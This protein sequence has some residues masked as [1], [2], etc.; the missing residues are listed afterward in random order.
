MADPPIYLDGF[1]YQLADVDP[2]ETAEWIEALD[3]V[4][5]IDGTRRAGYLMSRLLERARQ[6]SVAVP[7]S[8]STPYVN[9]IP[10]ESDADFPGDEHLEKRIRRF[11][12]WNAAAMV[13]RANH[14]A[15][16]IGGHLSTFASSA[17]LYEVGFNHFFRGK[18]DG[19]PGDHIY[20]QG[21]AT[22]GLYA[23]AFLEGRLDESIL[24]R[25]RREIGEP[26][27]SSYPHP[28]LMPDFW[29]YPTVSMG[30]GP[31]N[32][33][34]HAQFLKYLHN[35]GIDDTS[36]TRIWSF[37]GDGETDEPETLGSISLA[38]RENLDNL[39]WV[40]NCNLQRL[41]GPV[42]GNGK[43]IQELEAMFRG[44]G[45]NVIKVIWGS[46]WDDLL[47]RDT[48]GALVAKM[49]STVDGEYQRFKAESGAYVRENFFG[50]EAELQA[51]V[52]DMTDEEI[53]KLR[54]G[55]LDHRKIYSAYKSAVEVEGAP[56]AI[57][58]KT[59]KGWT[60][61]ADV[62]GKN[63]THSIKHLTGTQLCDLRD[64]L[65][66]HDEI[67][68][69]DLEDGEPPYLRF[70]EDSPEFQYLMRRRAILN[71]PVPTR[72]LETRSP[73]VLPDHAPF[74]E[75]DAGSGSI[76]VSTTGAFTRLLRALTR[77]ANVG[78]RIVPIIPDEGRTF[79]MDALFKEIKIYASE[80]QLYEP[81][82]HDLILS[83]KESMD[84]QILEQGITEAG[85]T[86]SWIAAATS[87]VTRGVPMIPFYTFYSMFGFQRVG[88][89]L[90]AASD[91]GARGFLLG[92][93]AGRTTLLGEGLQHQDGHSHVLASVI[94]AC[95]TY[96]PAFAYEM[97][98]IIEHGMNRMYARGD[99]VFYYLTLYNENYVQPPKPPG[100]DAGIIAGMYRFT[101]RARPGALSA[102]ILF[103][104]PAH[105]AASRAR[106]ELLERY[107]VSADTWSVT[108]YKKLREDALEVE[109]WNRF[110]PQDDSRI[111]SITRNLSDSAGPVVAV[112][113]Y[114]RIVPDQVARFV[115]RPYVSLGTDGY[116]RSDTREALR[117]FFEVRSGDIV[118]AVLSQLAEAG[119]IDRSVVVEAIDLY[120]IDPTTA[121]PWQR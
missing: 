28:R 83:Y 38:G 53:W 48:T 88:D 32:S 77:D 3:S 15:N 21:H 68:D 40:V 19:T 2:E 34:Y 22:P 115:R 71:G 79:G 17:T 116:G 13:I 87:Y 89:A 55:G 43:I 108:S 6:E 20:F 104:G 70:S 9:T 50:P 64:R 39:T 98:T 11:V 100:V 92:A 96:D 12:R 95:E 85:A 94:P 86:S 62:A 61:G 109:R 102:T 10:A 8:V 84:G 42:R 106:E 65:H 121:P 56:T 90:W 14:A 73:L 27:L 16:G 26:G 41:D 111:P 110:H 118:V 82:D 78:D 30:L 113:D 35:R 117:A 7:G 52:A 112:T 36:G 76:E 101:E 81:V 46:G 93:T 47:A 97:A 51:M 63:A 120:D 80:G 99:N 57:L 1:T 72:G 66:L 29:E 114:M 4:I 54:R 24:D 44:A 60:L 75:F 69:A 37:L 91:S 49:N 31:I 18:A 107:G 105:A 67:P 59:I 5:A 58:A 45:W 103:S 23:R 119:S 74:A 33:I 25:F